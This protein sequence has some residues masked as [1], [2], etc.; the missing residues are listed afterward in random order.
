M[1]AP[2]VTVAGLEFQA[3]ARL[4]WLRLL[5]AA[6][7][8]IAA[9]AAYAAG[10]ASDL[11]GADGFERTTMTLVPVVIILVPLAGLILGITGQTAEAGGEP[12]LF[13]QPVGRATVLL[14]RWLGESAAL[15]AGIAVGF[16]LGG[17]IVA[18]S[19]GAAGALG[20]AGFVFASVLLG[21]IFVAIAAAVAAAAAGRAAALGVGVFVWFVFVLLYDAAALSLARSIGGSA[22]GRVLFVSVFLNPADLMRIAMLAA[23]GAPHVLGA[24]GDAWIRFVGGTTTTVVVASAAL[25]AWIAAPLTAGILRL[26]ARD[27]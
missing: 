18:S 26:R 8:S 3:A 23:G 14:G 13:A 12:F 2:L 27:L 7:A 21:T 9:A 10:A 20:Y 24:A 6:F 25:A 19:G 11:S 1:I 4:R 5:A 17:A 16:G 22:G 15:A